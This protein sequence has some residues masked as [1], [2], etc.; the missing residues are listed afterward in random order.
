VAVSVT[1][2]A[3]RKELS[4][5][6]VLGLLANFYLMSQL[7]ITNWLRFLIWLL[8]GLVLYFVYGI[9]HSRLKKQM[10]QTEV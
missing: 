7:G 4:L 8:I 9:R 10:D 1:W 3:I 5:I 2:I 6:P